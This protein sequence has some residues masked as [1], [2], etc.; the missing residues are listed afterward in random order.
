MN[1]AP[2]PG[3]VRVLVRVTHKDGL[4][5]VMDRLGGEWNGALS[6]WVVEPGVSMHLGRNAAGTLVPV[7]D[8]AT[9]LRVELALRDLRGHLRIEWQ[10][11]GPSALPRSRE[12]IQPTA[13]T[14]RGWSTPKPED[15]R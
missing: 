3:W 2:P 6:A 8:P 12:D 1:A 5:G 11:S 14:N 10:T 4:A 9:R 7:M 15:W 13:R